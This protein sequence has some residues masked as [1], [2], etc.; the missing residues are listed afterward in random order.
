MMLQTAYIVVCPMMHRTLNVW[1]VSILADHFER[2]VLQVLLNGRVVHLASNQTFGI[3]YGVVGV[4]RSLILC[5]VS[6]K[7]L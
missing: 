6:N 7:A 4:H 2:P 5:C 3:E 1:L